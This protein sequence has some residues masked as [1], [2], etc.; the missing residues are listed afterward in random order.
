MEREA[1]LDRFKF[2]S[3]PIPRRECFTKDGE[4]FIP[5]LRNVRLR[6]NTSRQ[7]GGGPSCRLRGTGVL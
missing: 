3:R 5:R 6:G 2:L 1:F 4:C 7:G